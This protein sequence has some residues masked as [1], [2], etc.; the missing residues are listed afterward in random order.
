MSDALNQGLQFMFIGMTGVFCFLVLMV[1]V[2]VIVGN[3]L[4]KYAHLFPEP[5]VAK[6]SVQQAPDQAQIAIAIAAAYH[7]AKK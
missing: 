5:V 4:Q 3:F 7:S 6:P 1:I 2:M